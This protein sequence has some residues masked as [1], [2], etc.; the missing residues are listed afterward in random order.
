MRPLLF[1]LVTSCFASLWATEPRSVSYDQPLTLSG[2]IIREYDMSFVD[3]DLSPLRDPKAV[4][5][6]VAEA[7]R[8]HALDESKPLHQPSPHLILQL[9]I[10]ISVLG[11]EGDDF[12]PAERNVREI[13]LGA[14]RPV[15]S[16]DLGKT[17]FR[18][19]GKLWHAVTVHH[20]RPIMMKVTAWERA[21]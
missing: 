21:K 19:S 4:A 20:L 12:C 8:N 15:Q 18:V 1:L 2:T 6:A 7:R 3:S 11:K 10:P 5:R 17:R 13:D 9:D 14:E 16:A